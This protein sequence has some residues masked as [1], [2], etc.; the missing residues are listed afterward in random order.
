MDRAISLGHM[1]EFCSSLVLSIILLSFIPSPMPDT[2]T[3]GPLKFLFNIQY[4]QLPY[5]SPTSHPQ[6]KV[7][8]WTQ[9]EKA[10]EEFLEVAYGEA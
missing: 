2:L 3:R 10:L 5:N 4:L 7:L 8:P 9:P 6:S 1:F